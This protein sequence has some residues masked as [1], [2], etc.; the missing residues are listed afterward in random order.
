MSDRRPWARKTIAK[1]TAEFAAWP[2]RGDKPFQTVLPAVVDEPYQAAL[3]VLAES[4][5]IEKLVAE[6]GGK[7]KFMPRFAAAWPHN[8]AEAAAA[9]VIHCVVRTAADPTCRPVPIKMLVRKREEIE[10]AQKMVAFLH[11]SPAK[12]AYSRE[13]NIR[14]RALAPPADPIVERR[15]PTT[16]KSSTGVKISSNDDRY[17]HARAMRA[18]LQGETRRIFGKAGDHVADVFVETVTGIPCSRDD[19][20]RWTR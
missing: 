18:R 12:D 10:S 4:V 9:L 15:R 13:L 19:R 2:K 3:S 1:I 7:I 6:F 16:K 11:P 17:A 20:R 8:A 5:A 14:L